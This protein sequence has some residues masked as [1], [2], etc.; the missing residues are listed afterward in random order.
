MRHLLCLF[1]L[2]AVGGRVRSVI[3]LALVLAAA[4]V[5]WL[6][7]SNQSFGGLPLFAARS[8][9]GSRLGELFQLRR[10]VLDRLAGGLLIGRQGGERLRD[11]LVSFDS[12]LPSDCSAPDQNDVLVDKVSPN[13]WRI[14]QNVGDMA[15]ARVWD[16]DTG[17]IGE[18]VLVDMSDFELRLEN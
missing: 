9:F 17:E 16:T 7:F 1:A 12:T 14:T 4:P 13:T 11:L 10:V 8:G 15:C 6:G 18:P 3:S 2:A 5:V